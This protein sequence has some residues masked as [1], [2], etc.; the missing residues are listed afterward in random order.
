MSIIQYDSIGYTLVIL[1]VLI[2]VQNIIGNILEPK[3][4]GYQLGINPMFILI[5]LLMWGY[6]WG[7]IGMFMSVPLTAIIKII[8][9]NA[10]SK[11]LQFINKLMSN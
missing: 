10:N 7:I 3:I 8:L 5:S 9:S 4:F 6:T 11:N 1:I 2:V